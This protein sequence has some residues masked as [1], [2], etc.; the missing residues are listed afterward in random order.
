[1]SSHHQRFGR[2]AAGQKNLLHRRLHECRRNLTPNCKGL[3]AREEWRAKA[4]QYTA[5]HSLERTHIFVVAQAQGPR[6]LVCQKHFSSCT[7]MFHVSSSLSDSCHPAPPTTP[8]SSLSCSRGDLLRDPNDRA[9]FGRLAEQSSFT[10]YEPN[11]LNEENN[12]EVAP[13]LF[14]GGSA[15]SA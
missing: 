1:M 2:L 11:N 9:Q 3:R 8:S 14:Q 6:G 12:S 7:R 5:H 15:C 13:I 4:T 10:K